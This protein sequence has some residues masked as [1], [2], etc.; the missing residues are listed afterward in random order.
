MD[1]DIGIYLNLLLNGLSLSVIFDNFN[2]TNG[3]DGVNYYAMV[4]QSKWNCWVHSIGMLFT[5][6]GI[7]CWFPALLPITRYDRNKLQLYTWFLYFIHYLTID[8]YGALL[9]VIIYSASMYFAYNRVYYEYD[10]VRLFFHGILISTLSLLFQEFVGHYWGGDDPSR[11]TVYDISNAVF[12]APLFS[13]NH[14]M[15]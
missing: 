3:I 8:I 4:H 15:K 11:M 6:Y 1:T 9:F 12:Y 7:S 13:V 10:D 14:F 5:F 2:I